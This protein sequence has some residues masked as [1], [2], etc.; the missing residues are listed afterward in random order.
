MNI[1]G[2][3]EIVVTEEPLN[4]PITH[5]VSNTFYNIRT[6]GNTCTICRTLCK[7][8]AELIV[9]C[10]NKSFMSKNESG[11]ELAKARGLV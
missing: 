1:T 9:A 7:E 3:L 6:I 11:D 2:K 8:D 10:V 5:R 4:N